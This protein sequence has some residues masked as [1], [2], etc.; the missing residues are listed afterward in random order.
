MV[1]MYDL[2]R[3]YE[4]DIWKTSQV[5]CSFPTTTFKECTIAVEDKKSGR[6]LRDGYKVT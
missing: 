3:Q 5:V 1:E 4:S 2:Q 6:D